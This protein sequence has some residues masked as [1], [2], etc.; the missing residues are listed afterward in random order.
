MHECMG[1]QVRSLGENPAHCMWGGGLEGTGQA[2]LMAL[3]F[4]SMVKTVP[5]YKLFVHYYASASIFKGR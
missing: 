2:H 3:A 5:L 1:G 4:P